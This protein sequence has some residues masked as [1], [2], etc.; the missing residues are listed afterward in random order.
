MISETYFTYNNRRYDIPSDCT[1]SVGNTCQTRER[2]MVDNTKTS[3]SIATYTK[4]QA[5]TYTLGFQIG[6]YDFNT[7]NNNMTLKDL[8]QEV[9][10]WESLAGKQIQFVYCDINYGNCIITDVSVTYQLDASSGITGVNLQFN[11][12]DNIVIP[13]TPEIVNVRAT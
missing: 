11:I 10:M 2:R 8:L 13:R 4:P 9:Y 12:K 6:L 7:S 5:S 3:Y 1:L